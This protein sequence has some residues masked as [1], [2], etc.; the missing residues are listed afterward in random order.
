M[1][2][3]VCLSCHSDAK[4]MDTCSVQVPIQVVHLCSKL[5]HLLPKDVTVLT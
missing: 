2:D 3:Y 5:Y 1:T 4:S